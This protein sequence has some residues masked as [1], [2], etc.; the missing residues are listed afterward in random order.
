MVFLCV[1]MSIYLTYYK[2][3]IFGMITFANFV[4]MY[5]Y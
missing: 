1:E 3:V 2:D 4:G 5:I